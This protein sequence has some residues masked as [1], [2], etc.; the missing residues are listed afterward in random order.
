MSS[1]V[2]GLVA[3]GA[4]ILGLVT[5]CQFGGM[6][7]KQE[8]VAIFDGK[9]LEGWIQYPAE[10]WVVKD[11][12]MASTGKGRGYICTTRDYENYRLIFKMRH[13]SG[14]HQ[15][16]VLV[17]GNLPSK[18]TPNKPDA[19]AAIQ[20]QPP[21]GFMWDYRPGHNTGTGN[22]KGSK[23][24]SKFTRVVKPSFKPAEWSQVEILVNAKDGTARMAVAQPVG[25]K[26]I[27]VLDFKDPALAGKK[28]PVA[29]Q[30][31]NG[32]LF[33]EYKDVTIEENPGSELTT[34]K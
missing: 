17:F 32:G 3:L 8:K 19:L 11:G 15:A 22:P 12:A 25:T 34:T 30:I 29:W 13:V 27:E 14:N 31:H 7:P 5:G 24:T 21:N 10:S 26:A 20:F 6:H 4:L 33:D 23:D 28:G 2:L 9:T 1:R 18:E 16:C